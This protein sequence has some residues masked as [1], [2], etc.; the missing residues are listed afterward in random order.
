M[1]R[2]D[3]EIDMTI[4]YH[5]FR[6]VLHGHSPYIRI[7][8][9][10]PDTSPDTYLYPPQFAILLSPLGHFSIPVY[11]RMWFCV[12]L[13]AFWM[14]AYS[15]ARIS[16]VRT[17]L[18]GVICW[19][20]ALWVFPNINYIMSVGQ[21]DIVMGAAVASATAAGANRYWLLIASNIKPYAIFPALVV[22]LSERS[23]VWKETWP[24]SLWLV[25]LPYISDWIRDAL[26]VIGQGTFYYENVSVPFS[27]LRLLRS[28]GIWHYA[29][30]P[31]SAGPR[32]YLACSA[33][34]GP[35]VTSMICRKMNSRR[36]IAISAISTVVFAPICWKHYLVLCYPLLACL[37]GEKLRLYNRDSDTAASQPVAACV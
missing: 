32:M 12:L 23:I 25:G 27:V 17:T 5:A 36:L 31:L 22:S 26:S 15:L 30:G 29:H 24:L 11:A 1:K 18:N 8:G 21:C 34:V 19:A 4:Y 10:G 20:A 33:V 37:I 2:A 16:Q 7:P 13:A 14:F 9:Y 6:A 28:L 3:D 35:V